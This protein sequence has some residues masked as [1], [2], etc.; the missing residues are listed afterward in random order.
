M[1]DVSDLVKIFVNLPNHWNTNGESMWARPLGNDLYEL[2]NSPFSAYDLNY[3]DVVVALSADPELK[4]QISRIERRSGHKTLR[5][6][7]MAET[8]RMERDEILAQINQLGASYENANSTLYSLDI[9]PTQNYESLCDQLW[10]W[11]QTGVLEYETCEA[12]MPGSFDATPQGG[13]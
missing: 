8:A 6:I 11:E 12:R 10:I 13:E 9:P 2:H 1:R 5:L 4:P 7:F 3:L